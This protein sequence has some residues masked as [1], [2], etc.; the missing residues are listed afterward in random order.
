MVKNMDHEAK[1]QEQL[2]DLWF[3][4]DEGLNSQSTEDFQGSENSLMIF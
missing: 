3:P 2:K 1:F 4:G